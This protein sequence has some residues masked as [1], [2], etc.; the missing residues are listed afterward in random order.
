[1]VH[2]SVCFILISLLLSGHAVSQEPAFEL[3]IKQIPAIDGKVDDIAAVFDTSHPD[4]PHCEAAVRSDGT[5]CRD[6]AY[7]LESIAVPRSA[8]PFQVQIVSTPA[9]ASDEYLKTTFPNQPL[10]ELRHTC[11]G[12]LI[13]VDWVLTAAHCIHPQASEKHYGVRIDVDNISG[14]AAE[15]YTIKE[16]IRHAEYDSDSK[17][18]DIAL[19][20]LDIGGVNTP[21]FITP[22]RPIEDGVDGNMFVQDARLV[23]GG[24]R[25]VTYGRNR[26]L[27]L[28]DAVT[29]AA[30]KETD[31]TQNLSRG[32]Y[33]EPFEISGDYIYSRQDNGVRSID[34]RAGQ[35]GSYYNFGAPI[36]SAAVNTD[37][38]HIVMWDEYGL[39][40]VWD[41]TRPD[42]PKSYRQDTMIMNARVISQ[43]RLF[44]DYTDKSVGLLDMNGEVIASID[45]LSWHG[46]PQFINEGRQIVVLGS[47][48]LSAIDVA[49]GEQGRS[50]G[51]SAE[52]FA[53]E[54]RKFTRLK[55]DPD[56]DRIM[57]LFD[58]GAELWDP[59]RRK[60]L[61]RMRFSMDGFR[62]HIDWKHS[63]MV[64]WNDEGVALLFDMRSG[65]KVRDFDIE[66]YKGQL[67][68]RVLDSGDKIM[69]S[70]PRGVTQILS[71]ST[72]A[73]VTT[74]DHSLPTSMVTLT[75]NE[76]YITSESDFGTVDVRDA[77][78]GEA[79]AR[80]FHGGSV[81]GTHLSVDG[82]S[83]VSWGRAGKTR[84]W[85]IE[86][87]K[88]T[89][90]FIHWSAPEGSRAPRNAMDKKPAIISLV[91]FSRLDA[92]IATSEY[93]T[94][95]GWGK[96]REPDDKNFEPSSVLRMLALR[97]IPRETCMRLGKWSDTYLN[98]DQR[99]FCAHDP[100][101][102][103]CYGDSGGPV[104]GNNR[105]VGIV[106]WGSQK[107][108]I[109]GTPSVYTRVSHYA[110][111]IIKEACSRAIRQGTNRP[112]FCY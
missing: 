76:K 64:L 62:W 60:R 27:R 92:D 91:G 78:T 110:N 33:I 73:I 35:W 1:M 63:R 68:V 18:N 105:V 4:E 20:Q 7:S 82:K 108:E 47:E 70:Y 23:A 17:A 50:F 53:P 90:R 45:D 9:L 12:A 21:I 58:K 89:Q 51:P 11:G 2:R 66:K 104:M 56:D 38:G 86:T 46:S 79:A 106:S 22:Y 65:R 84:I 37:T 94:A 74:M 41:I 101:R 107:C 25:L 44:V 15:V 109:D 77:K 71:A 55:S 31:I 49:T 48:G 69:L 83:L 97:E 8:A 3:P 36:K 42:E 5:Q 81:L 13:A 61:A 88:E 52:N 26:Q 100:R 43:S 57:L 6:Q 111:W 39:L 103:T 80:L 59:A 98:S 28:W 29:G 40:K 96:T 87:G 67:S 93:L 85:D 102:K 14:G 112:D 19:L 72:G 16:I 99:A 75:E 32:Y 30:L 95:F 24:K 54:S 34:A 10:W